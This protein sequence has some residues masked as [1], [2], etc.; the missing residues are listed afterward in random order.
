[1]AHFGDAERPRPVEAAPV[2][3]LEQVPAVLVLGF[4]VRGVQRP[5][6]HLVRLVPQA[7]QEV[8]D[9]P[10][11]VVVDLDPGGRE[12]EEFRPQ[13]AED[14]DPDLVRRDVVV[15]AEPGQE[16]AL[17]SGPS[18]PGTGQVHWDSAFSAIKE[19]GYDGW[20][21]IEA[22]GRALPDL[23]AATRVWRDLFP[24]PEQVYRDGIAFIRKKWSE[25]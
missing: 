20:L 14:R 2:P 23:A 9:V 15:A 11:A 16:S 22:F 25:A 12:G 7:G 19:T 10:R 17:G 8:P 18:T 1:M 3:G 13:P 21:V 4:V 6:D 5:A 24:A